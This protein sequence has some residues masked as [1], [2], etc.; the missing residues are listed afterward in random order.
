MDRKA[1]QQVVERKTASLQDPGA[2][3]IVA[4]L[5]E[6]L[7]GDHMQA[8]LGA[9]ASGFP[10][11]FQ[12]L[13]AKEQRREQSHSILCSEGILVCVLMEGKGKGF[14]RTVLHFRGH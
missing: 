5:E 3:G 13:E 10:A 2:V 6:E 8:P 1:R 14:F 9:M 7:A 11:T 4:K 12:E